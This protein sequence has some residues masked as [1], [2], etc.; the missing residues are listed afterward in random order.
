MTEPEQLNLFTHEQLTAMTQQAVE[1]KIQ[2][3]PHILIKLQENALKVATNARDNYFKNT[4]QLISF[5]QQKNQDNHLFKINHVENP[6]WSNFQNEIVTFIDGGVGQIDMNSPVPILIRVGSYKVKTGEH[7]ISKREEFTYYPIIF[8]DLEGGSKERKDF[9]DIVRITSELLGAIAALE[10]TPDLKVLMIHG[11]LVYMMNAYAG[12]TPFTEKDIDLF[13]GH[14]KGSEQF[15]QKLKNDF[16]KDAKD[17][18]Y[19]NCTDRDN[20]EDRQDFLNKRL[21]EP[22]SW[23]SFLYQ[24]LIREAHNKKR[25]IKPIIMGVVE[26][27]NLRE[28]SFNLFNKIF[29]D[30]YKVNQEGYFNN[31]YGRTDLNNTH[32]FLERLGYT[33]TLLLSMLLEKQEFSEPLVIKSKYEN[34]GQGHIC[35]PNESTKRK[36]NWSPLKPSNRKKGFPKITAFYLKVSE[37]TEPIRIEVFNDLG[38]EQVLEAAKRVYLYSQLLP[39]YGFPVGLDVVD[40]YAKIPKWMT[41]AYAKQIQ[42]HLAVSLQTGQITDEQMRQLLIQSI[43]MTKRDWLFR[44]NV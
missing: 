44:P 34:L 27:N 9:V 11:P 8:G 12:H 2:K 30:L 7:D 15:A 26:R 33:D 25:K 19:Y 39:G 22:L 28:F 14:Y 20:P 21:F 16:L 38:K 43:Y 35:F 1:D 17:F 41:D 3:Q 4:A 37:T 23:I 36:F 18:Y 10:R 5:L 42:Y 6:S 29:D 13:L 32:I 24:R 31:L 40:K